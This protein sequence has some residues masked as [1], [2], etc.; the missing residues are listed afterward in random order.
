MIARYWLAVSITTFQASLQDANGEDT[1]HV[2]K[3]FAHGRR[4][5][6]RLLRCLERNAFVLQLMNDVLQVLHG[7]R[8]VINARDECGTPLPPRGAP[9]SALRP[10]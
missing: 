6:D 3:H 1:Q 5:V 8:L 4:G 2:K 9:Y 7:A 10:T